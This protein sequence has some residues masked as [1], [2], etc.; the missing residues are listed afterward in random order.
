MCVSLRLLMC[1]YNSPPS[2]VMRAHGHAD[3]W[4]QAQSTGG[5]TVTRAGIGPGPEIKKK[6]AKL[7][8]L[9]KEVTSREVLA[10]LVVANRKPIPHKG[11]GVN[12]QFKSW[13]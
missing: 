13:Q 1:V 6:E 7:C 3:G 10:G 8:F 9:E 5:F 2:Y 4:I 12:E 11:Q